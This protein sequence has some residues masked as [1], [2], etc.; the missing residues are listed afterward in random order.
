MT[1]LTQKATAE[2][3]YA[4]IA[5]L[6][7]GVSS[8]A[9]T[10]DAMV[11][12]GQTVATLASP[13]DLTGAAAKSNSLGLSEAGTSSRALQGVASVLGA[14]VS[15]LLRGG[16]QSGPANWLKWLNPIASLFSLFGGEEET[17]GTAP[18][19][20][21]SRAPE[22]AHYRRGVQAR[23]GW[24]V[25]DVDYG[26]DG[27]A[28]STEWSANAAPIIVQVQTIDSRSFLDHSD[29]IADAVKKSLLESHALTDAL[30]EL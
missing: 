14:A 26:S 9:G 16:Q 24:R 4:E 18:A 11:L 20:V 13:G 29:A 2:K 30:R 23:T 12:P 19:K 15:P 22:A 1:E 7:Q 6:V 17:S 3:I 5:N 8:K 10:L 25:E 21:V 28:R 27:R